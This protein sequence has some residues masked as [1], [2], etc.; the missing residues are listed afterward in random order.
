MTGIKLKF[1]GMDFTQSVYSCLFVV[2][3][4]HVSTIGTT[5]LLESPL[6]RYLGRISFGIY[7]FHPVVIGA[8]LTAAKALDVQLTIAG[9][10][11]VYLS[12]VGATVAVAAL[13][14]EYFESRVLRLNANP[15]KSGAPTPS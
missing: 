8:V 9:Q 1:H 7:M 12:A 13:S 11:I 3:I 6:P 10:M 4:C 5:N 2:V 15:E 14:F